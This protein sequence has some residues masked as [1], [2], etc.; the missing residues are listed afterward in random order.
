V[1]LII[2]RHA[3]AIDRGADILDEKRYLTPEGRVSFRKTARTMVQKGMDPGLILTSPL[4]R[5]VQTADILAESLAYK[6]LLLAVDDLSP[7]FDQA[8]LE[9]LLDRCQEVEEL[10]LVGHEPDLG[11][12]VARLLSLAHGFTFKKGSAIRLNIDPKNPRESA[13]FK[14]LATGR[15]LITSKEEAFG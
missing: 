13:T 9:R 14:W 4:L 2:V 15:K 7:G 3:T 6:G 12:L 5:A 10:V 8:G 1:Q 11:I